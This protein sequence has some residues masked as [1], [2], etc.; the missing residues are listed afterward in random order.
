MRRSRAGRRG[1]S[2]P[3]SVPYDIPVTSGLVA[4]FDARTL[5]AGAVSSWASRGGS[6]GTSL[7]LAQSTAGN[8]PVLTTGVASFNGKS[9]VLF[10][11]VN[12]QL[13]GATAADWAFLSNGVGG[14]CF[15]VRRIDST[16]GAA[17]QL[18]TSS[19]NTATNIGFVYYNQSTPS[20]NHR[21]HNGTGTLVVAHSVASGARDATAWEFIGYVAGT[22]TIARSSLSD[23][24]ADTGA[25]PSASAPS[26]A[27]AVGGQNSNPASNPFKGYISQLLF[28]SRVLSNAERATTLA[29]WAATLYG[30][31]P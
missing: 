25:A 27:L 13:V 22:S 2:G 28:Y 7:T 26:F 11:G 8:R 24:A 18:L 21:V 19:N 3:A 9:A 30:V 31:T 1:S 4:W 14:S 15:I 12:D 17:Q 23:T 10:D 5:A 29:N 20:T 6:L 16:G